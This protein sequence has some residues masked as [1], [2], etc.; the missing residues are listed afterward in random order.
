M[1]QWSGVPVNITRMLGQVD[2]EDPTNLPIGCSWVC[3]NT[4]FTRDAVGGMT[5]ANTRAGN[6]LAMQGLPSPG[7]GFW[8]FQYESESA[9]DPFTGM[10]MPLLFTFSGVLQRE[11]PV[12]TGRM[13]AIGAGMFALPVSSHKIDDQAGNILWSAYSNLLTPTAGLSGFNPKT[14]NL[15]PLGMKPYGWNWLPNTPVVYL[16]EVATPSPQSGGPQGNGHTYQAQNNGATGPLEPIWPLT[17]GGTVIEVL[18]PAQIAKGLVPVTWKDE[19]MVIANRIP[20]PPAAVLTLTGGGTFPANQTVYILL[21]LTNGM[22]ETVAGITSSI[23]TTAAGQAVNVALPLPPA[24][25]NPLPGWLAQLVAPYAIAGATVYEA[26]VPFGSP[27][28]PQS[29]FELFGSGALGANVLVTGTAVGVNVPTINSARITPGQLPTPSQAAA[30]T[31][32]PAAGTFIAGRDVWVRLSYSNA[33]GETPLGPSNSIVNTLANDAILVSLTELN[34]AQQY[35]QLVIVNVYEADVPTGT[36]EPPISA[37]ALSAVS[38]VGGQVTIAGPASGKPPVLVNGTGPGG[39]VPADTPYGGI[40][41]TQGYRYAVPAWMNRNET[42]S[43]FTQ[44]AVSRYIVDEDGWEISVFNVPIGPL[45][46]IGRLINWTVA[47]GTQAGPFAWIGVVD[48]LV[49][50]QNLVYPNDY[51]SDGIE[52]TPTVFL[53]NATTTGTFNFTD[54][55]LTAEIEAGAEGNNT[56][57]R[58]RVTAPPTAV[59]VDYLTPCDRLALAGVPGYTSG[60]VISIAADYESYYGDTSPLPIPTTRGETC[61]GAVVFRNE[62][63][64]MRSQ[65]GVVVVPGAGDPSS[66]DLRWRWGPT[67]DAEGYGPCGPRAFAANAQFIVFVHRT[68]LYKYEGTGNPDL[69]VKEIPREWAT[70][71]WADAQTI[72]CTIDNDTHTVRLQVPTY[73]STVPN[74]EFCLSYLEGWQN[75]IHF[76]GYAQRESSQEAARRWSFNDISSFICRRILRIIPNPKPIQLGNDGTSQQTSDFNISQLA[77]TTTDQSGL[78]NARTPGR[79][80]DNG[81]GIDWIYQGVSAQAMQKPSK[82]EGI[83][84]SAVGFGQI[85][86]GFLPG[87]KKITSDKGRA[88]VLWANPM[89]LTPD[90]SVEIACRPTRAMNEYWSPVW[91]NGKVPGVWASIKKATIYIIPVKQTA[92]SLDSGMAGR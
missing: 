77:Y 17:E 16:N 84:T 34:D 86:V 54:Q 39:N 23:T 85:N 26:D 90:G 76:F 40:N 48:I 7:T 14:F 81:A 4:D 50:T 64:A 42:I 11:W 24:V 65:S 70:I 21:T 92:G 1:P 35:P 60:L 2:Q 6:C 91:T 58:L 67:K 73:N 74:M 12:G 88:A 80:D 25:G 19:T 59:R 38:D 89:D 5:A 83:V 36:T 29:A 22:G 71:N 33:N 66:W 46:I 49:P 45:N 20:A 10:Q 82:P 55:I 27:A 13:E 51:L 72:C 44:Q 57:D 56:T 31:R 87:R 79:Y 63:Y 47:D 30:L 3:R 18:S 61:W 15:D 37:Y 52:I 78:V 28:P 32:D 41:E 8:D 62:I 75:P 69:M 9:T 43:G 68:G 53:D